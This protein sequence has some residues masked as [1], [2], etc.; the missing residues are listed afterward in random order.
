MELNGPLLKRLLP[1]VNDI[2]Q[3]VRLQRIIMDELFPTDMLGADIKNSYRKTVTQLEKE[4]RQ[5]AHLLEEGKS[6]E[7][8]QAVSIL[9]EPRFMD[10]TGKD[11]TLSKTSTGDFEWTDSITLYQEFCSLLLKKSEE[12]SPPLIG[13]PFQNYI[14][15][16]ILKE[17]NTFNKKALKRPFQEIQAPIIQQRRY[18]LE[19]MRKVFD[20]D[21][22]RY[23]N[24]YIDLLQN[25]ETNII[26]MK[27][28]YGSQLP[29]HTRFIPSLK[30][31]NFSINKQLQQIPGSQGQKI[32]L[33]IELLE[34][35]HWGDCL[36]KIAAYLFTLDIFNLY[37]VFK[38][39]MWGNLHPVPS[40]ER[41]EF[42]NLI[43]Y[44]RQKELLIKET[45]A[46]I[47][48][49]ETNNIFLYGPPGTGKSSALNSLLTAFPRLRMVLMD[50]HQVS[51][52]TSVCNKVKDS[53]YPFIIAFDEL[54]YEADDE[55]YKRLQESI[56]G[57]VDKLP[58]NVRVY[59]AAN[60][61]YPVRIEEEE[62]GLPDAY[63]ALAD[64]FGLKIKFDLPDEPTKIEIL[65][66]YAHKKGVSLSLE[67]LIEGFH[68][69]C[70]KN[71]HYK[72]NGRNIRDYIRS[73]R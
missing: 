49:E 1:Q 55:T 73:L 33:K 68:N 13:S 66:Y 19:N 14:L 43:G 10:A 35:S 62:N 44:E 47:A 8:L 40:Y 41:Y 36:E 24:L 42:Q 53:D 45:A 2:C 32:R 30:G 63:A 65:K 64:R 3:S 58:D 56:E 39:D 67:Y 12:W 71:D 31:M 7:L 15:E 38:V 9:H 52:L 11:V 59:A 37:N 57:L 48:G 60:T 72:P 51:L 46:F 5:L 69:W 70:Q 26:R 20:F 61:K 21:L 6:D 54:S 27:D 18:F 4:T 29:D 16:L 22:E 34:N 17:D 28:S 25:I 23:M 50:K